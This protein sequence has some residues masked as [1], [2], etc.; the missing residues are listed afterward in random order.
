MEEAARK[1]Q[2]RLAALRA[3]APITQVQE[4][5]EDI[6]KQLVYQQADESEAAQVVQEDQAQE[7]SVSIFSGDRTLEDQMAVLLKEAKSLA[8]PGQ[9]HGGAEEV[10]LDEL[11]PKKA[12]W[13]LR[14]DYERRT[15]GLDK[16]YERACVE[17]IRSRVCV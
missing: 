11:A 12:N 6:I 14:Q 7:A 8:A 16:E 5:E 2:E 10:T 3:G 9:M 17:L 4:P 1:R 13:D 15:A